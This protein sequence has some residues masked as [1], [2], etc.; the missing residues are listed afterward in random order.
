[1]TYQY[2]FKR[3]FSFNP[4]E[5]R[6]MIITTII[7]AITMFMFFAKFFWQDIELT[8][9]NILSR[10]LTMIILIGI[11]LFI[12]IAVTKIIAIRKKYTAT[13]KSWFEGLLVG[14]VL[15]FI[16]NSY[17]PIF[18]PG[19]IETETIARLRHGVVL[20][21]ENKKDIFLI[22]ATAPIACIFLSIFFQMTYL[23][24]GLYFFHHG[25]IIAAL[26]AVFALIPA[27]NNIGVHL[28]YS[29]KL[30]YFVLFIFSIAF[31]IATIISAYYAPM[32]AVLIGGLFWVLFNKYLRKHI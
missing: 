14:F 7:I 17:L 19:M 29:R 9:T 22:L 8:I 23:V 25:M 24:T 11:I 13:Y 32:I 31:A 10:I 2:H 18:F 5:I 30:P 26:F 21:G 4:S 6:G 16:T 12:F 15:S 3:Y 27:P 28:F 1:M 20:P